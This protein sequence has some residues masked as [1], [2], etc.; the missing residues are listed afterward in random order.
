MQDP[1]DAKAEHCFLIWEEFDVKRGGLVNMLAIC[2]CS[3]KQENRHGNPSALTLCPEQT[4]QPLRLSVRDCHRLPQDHKIHTTI[5]W[6]QVLK[7]IGSDHRNHKE[8]Q[9][10]CVHSPWS[11]TSRAFGYHQSVLLLDMLNEQKCI[12]EDR[13]TSWCHCRLN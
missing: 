10:Q 6:P 12:S 4:P 7:H 1:L 2:W 9:T 8:K 11:L 13:F 5:I 3:C